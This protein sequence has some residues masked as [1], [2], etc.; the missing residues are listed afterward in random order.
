[1]LTSNNLPKSLHENPR[2]IHRLTTIAV[3]RVFA[4][5]KKGSHRRK[6]AK[7]R[8]ARLYQKI[9]NQR[10]DFVHKVTTGLVGQYDLICLE[11]LNIKG[12]ARTKLARIA[13]QKWVVQG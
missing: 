5:T 10:K 4:R 12:M 3:Q 11:D 7:R 6:K 13:H 1:M 8:V 2:E 9:R